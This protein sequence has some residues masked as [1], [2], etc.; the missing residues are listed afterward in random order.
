MEK[1]TRNDTE[2]IVDQFA[3]LEEE[4]AELDELL[5][6]NP[7]Y[8]TEEINTNDSI[9]L[10]LKDI[11][12]IPL[13]NADQEKELAIKAAHGDMQAFNSLWEANLR[14][15]ISVAK[16]Y[17]NPSRN[18]DLL[19]I[20]QDGNLGLS[21]A[22][23]KF[24]PSLNYKFSTYAYWWIKQAITRGLADKERNIRIPVHKHE[25]ITKQ[26]KVT[27]MLQ[28]ELGRDPSIKEIAKSMQISE[29]N[30]E[31]ILEF[32]QDTTSLDAFINDDEDSTL[33]DFISDE[34]SNPENSIM[35]SMLKNDI[36]RLVNKLSP[37]EANIIKLRFGLDGCEKCSL[38]ELGKRYNVTR[39]R[40]RQLEQN[41]LRQLRS[42]KEGSSL[43][44]YLVA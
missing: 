33:E 36:S 35:E 1:T 20:I 42:S 14:L 28:Q 2:N 27:R 32:A 37:R 15:V 16:K 43:K 41:A 4:E 39:E 22:I 17:Y 23:E 44:D 3:F 18:T 5:E 7:D 40:I 21:K 31:E 9:A 24:D 6:E 38:E 30:V 10:Y 29:K 8:D 19:D 25:E 26:M 11:G 13:L 34:T 12:R